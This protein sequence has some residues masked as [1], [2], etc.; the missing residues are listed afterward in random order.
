M[1]YIL[2][3]DEDLNFRGLLK[4]FIEKKF[5]TKVVEV[6]SEKEAL[7]KIDRRKPRMVFI[8]TDADFGSGLDFLETLKSFEVPV[9]A[10][11][12][13]NEREYIEKLISYRIEGCLLKTDVL[14]QLAERLE[15]I[16]HRYEHLYV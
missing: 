10:L 4:K 8:N 7:D 13:N 6:N 11:T 16:F 1:S 5:M 9:I 14:S 12:A 15:R 2:L 3:I